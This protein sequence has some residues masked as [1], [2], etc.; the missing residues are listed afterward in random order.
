MKKYLIDQNQLQALLNVLA[1]FPAKQV[2]GAI[3]LIRNLK[4][5]EETENSNSIIE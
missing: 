4:E 5:Y 2:I 3:D 1:E